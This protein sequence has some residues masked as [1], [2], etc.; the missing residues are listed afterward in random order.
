MLKKITHKFLKTDSFEDYI[1][2]PSHFWIKSNFFIKKVFTIFFDEIDKQLKDQ[3]INKKKVMFL[4]I[5]DPLSCT[6]SPQ[7]GVHSVLIL[8][9]CYKLLSSFRFSYGL[10]IIA[11]EIGHI[12]KEHGNTLDKSSLQKQIEAD[13]FAADLGHGRELLE[14]WEEYKDLDEIESR[15][16]YLKSYIRIIEKNG[17]IHNILAKDT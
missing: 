1:Q 13:L 6:I 15:I 2:K 12:I 10:A 3:I 8:P 11:H 9:E 5:N 14:V 4:K 16:D 17:G 7:K